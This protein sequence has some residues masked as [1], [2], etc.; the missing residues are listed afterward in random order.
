MEGDME[1][2]QEGVN[3]LWPFSRRGLDPINFAH[4]TPECLQFW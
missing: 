1:D 2:C 4:N 3:P